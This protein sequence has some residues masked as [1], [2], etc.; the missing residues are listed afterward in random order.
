MAKRSNTRKLKVLDSEEIDTL[1][2]TYLYQGKT[3]LYIKRNLGISKRRIADVKYGRTKTNK[4]D[5]A[6]IKKDVEDKL[7]RINYKAWDLV[8]GKIDHD[9]LSPIELIA[10][11]DKSFIQSRLIKNESTENISVI[12]KIIENAHK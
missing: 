3:Y 7:D 12:S 9:E 8:E 6:L 5:K 10:A 1:I 11:A 4:I 2:Q